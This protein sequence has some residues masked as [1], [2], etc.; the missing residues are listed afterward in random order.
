MTLDSLTQL[1]TECFLWINGHH[2]PWFDW[3]MWAFSQHWMWAIVLTAVFALVTLR[4]DS[5]RWWIVVVGVALCFLLADQT[6]VLIKNIVM[7]PRPCHVLPDVTMFRTKCGGQ[8]GF[9]SSHAANILAV[10]TFILLRYRNAPVKQ[11]LFVAAITIWV[12]AVC[13]SRVYLG[14]HYPGDV[15]CGAILG[16][17]IGVLVK[18]AITAL[19]K[20]LLK[21]TH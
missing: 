18:L 11:V 21:K 20:N 3:V 15:L 6:S 13:Y 17:L 7:R 12:V 5:K 14:K 1:D 16:L 9:V 4:A 2:T 8:Y 19:E 10:A